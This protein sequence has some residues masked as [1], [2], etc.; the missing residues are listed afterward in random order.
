MTIIENK[1]LKQVMDSHNYESLTDTQNKAFR[2]DI[3]D[4]DN[5]LLI[6]KTGNGKTLCAEVLSNKSISEDGSVA[7]LVPSRQLV[8]DK[9][10]EIKEWTTEVNNNYNQG[11]TVST[12]DSFYQSLLNERD[13]VKNLDLVILDDFH[14]IYSSYRGPKIEKTISAIKRNN[15][16]IFGMSATIGN[17]EEISN[18]LDARITISKEEREIEIKEDFIER[19]QSLSKK[20][21]VAEIIKNNRG[22][23]PFLVF[24]SS[25]NNAESR[26][27]EISDSLDVNVDISVKKDIKN[28]MNN[29][30]PPKIQELIEI[31]R[32]G[33]A[34]HHA[35]LPP[36]VKK[37][38]EDK[39]EQGDI[40]VI[41]CTTTIAYG[42]DSPVKSVLVADLKRYDG[43][44]GRMSYVGV[45]EFVQWIGRAARPGNGY[46]EG[47]ALIL[48]SNPDQ[49][50]KK[51]SKEKRELERIRSYLD[52]KKLFRKY[53]LELITR[54]WNTTEEIENFVKNTL[55]YNQISKQ[56]SWNQEYNMSTDIL[57][58]QL[59][60]VSEWL[61]Q[62][63]FIDGATTY[64]G[65]ESTELGESAIDFSFEMF[66]DY[67]LSTIRKYYNYLKNN[68]DGPKMHL[69]NTLKIFDIK[70]YSGKAKD[71]FETKLSEKNY[72]LDEYGITA[73][74]IIEYWC[75]N[76]KLSR[77]ERETGMEV[78]SL[79][80][81]TDTLSKIL[82]SSERLYTAVPNKR[83]PEW[84]DQVT[85]RIKYGVTEE[86]IQ[87]VKEV[88][89]VGRYRV[90]KFRI[91]IESLETNK[92]SD[93]KSENDLIENSKIY[94]ER[95]NSDKIEQKV[96]GFGAK[97]SENIMKYFKQTNQKDNT[98][99]NLS[100]DNMNINDRTTLDD[101]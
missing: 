78:T 90:R 94:F 55:Y 56:N 13:G 88:N 7:Y 69:Y 61:E 96:K 41:S 70:L 62:Y 29:D 39:F 59:R 64:D 34:Y 31:M 63:D 97:M 84:L 57:T 66:R 17:P 74:I 79:K 100:E 82:K 24:N 4:D 2:N 65:F 9:K 53:I 47:Y 45:W 36:E 73:G 32:N 83:K 71:E 27:R 3:L 101:F 40:K 48:T 37:Y 21:N 91:Y 93:V 51:Y 98:N 11:I 42:F 54:N 19:N 86:E 52:N 30:I 44:K 22:K 89:G 5:H 92:K 49:A 75:N 14:E 87:I 8:R 26:A 68:D 95:D 20:K 1:Y 6:A 76:K 12:F 80:S 38:I 23:A 18:W 28:I 46:N 33:V 16:Q 81:I 77:I 67:S 43:S 50:F 99:N 10:R 25:R 35:G 15:I 85:D 58:K 60:E 72:P